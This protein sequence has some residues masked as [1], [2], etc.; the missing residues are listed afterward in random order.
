MTA[1]KS[2]RN[3]NQFTQRA[4]PPE[5]ILPGPRG[6]IGAPTALRRDI[7]SLLK[8]IARE[9]PIVHGRTG[10][11]F[12]SDCDFDNLIAEFLGDDAARQ[13][14][15]LLDLPWPE[16]YE[17]ASVFYG[18]VWGRGLNHELCPQLDSILQRHGSAW[19]FTNACSFQRL[20]PDGSRINAPRWVWEVLYG[21]RSG[22]DLAGAVFSYEAIPRM[23]EWTCTYVYTAL[24]QIVDWRLE[25]STKSLADAV[26]LALMRGV[27]DA[28]A[29]DACLHAAALQVG[30]FSNKIE[31]FAKDT[32]AFSLGPA[33]VNFI[34]ATCCEAIVAFGP[35]RPERIR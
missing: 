32:A 13:W 26:P 33:D 10:G 20:L 34:F 4:P 35:P 17:L 5:I 1:K 18:Q 14:E 2:W 9:Q 8:A 22:W 16:V 19:E 7:L 23:E 28:K 29:A 11:Q 21:E 6:V 25:Q 3:T 30:N 12:D 27:I 31:D 24:M 15:I